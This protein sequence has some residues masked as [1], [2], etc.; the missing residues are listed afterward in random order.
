MMNLFSKVLL[1]VSVA[2][3]CV[4]SQ[5]GQNS[6]V[7]HSVFG[8][9]QTPFW[10]FQL[11][12]MNQGVENATSFNFYKKDQRNKTLFFKVS[13]ND[14]NNR[15]E[16]RVREVSGGAVLF[17]INDDDRYQLDLGGTYDVI[18]DTT[19]GE[20]ALYSRITYRPTRN[21]WFRFGS[22]Y[23]DGFTTG[24]PS[25]YRSTFLNSNYFAGKVTVEMFSLLAL[26]GR[27]KIDNQM[28][29][30]YGAAGIFNG[31][32]NLMLLAGYIQS[33][34]AK[35]NVRTL[36]IGRGAPY[37]PDG[38]PSGIFIWK[39]KQ[40][41]D[42]Q[43]GGIFWGK[44][45]LVVQP[46]IIGMSQGMFISST[47]LRENSKLRQGQ[48]MS[49]T[50]DYRNSD[51]TLFYVYLNQGITIMPNTINHVGIRAVQLYKIFDEIDITYASKPVVGLFYNEETSPV[52]ISTRHIFVDEVS[53]YFS[54]QIGLTFAEK[55][56]LN[57]I[58]APQKDEWTTAL[59]FVY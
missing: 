25:P 30:R 9:P 53:K 26:V 20:K 46:A 35:E 29:T 1:F 50:D 57:V 2:T 22:E 27:G 18:H 48:F 8:P 37:Q 34:D 52:F 24:H 42:F 38:L 58:H 3:V 41:Y 49:I 13:D 4:H 12:R 31:P 19:L 33:D 32:Y 7:A 54:C 14:L 21:F 44:K 10:E 16:F 51:I 47:A 17:P 28:H 11:S 15:S 23:F 56:I 43:L 40:N 5:H 45:N 36:A 6:D 55:V 59:S 39:H